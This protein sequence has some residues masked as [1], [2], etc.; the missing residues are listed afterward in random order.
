MSEVYIG[1]DLGSSGVKAVAMDESANCVASQSVPL[2]THRSSGGKAEHRTAEWQS[3]AG[4]CLR[5]LTQH[6]LELGHTPAGVACTGQ[7]NG[8][9]LLDSH[10]DPAAP[11][12]MWCDARCADQC[13]EI[14]ARI[15]AKTL[16]DIT[17]HHAVTGYTAP[18]LMWLAEHEPDVLLR[19]AH[20]VFPKDYL[21]FLLT[22]RV[23]TDFSDASNSLLLDVRSGR[24]EETISTTLGLGSVPLPPLA[25][26]TDVVGFIS[27]EGAAWSGLPEGLP[28]AGG[29]GD[30]IAAALGAGLKDTTA[31]QIVVGSAGNVNCV[32]G[33]PLVDAKGR[34]HTGFFVDR[35]HWICSGVLQAAGASLQ[36]WADIVGMRVDEMV[37]E[38]EPGGPSGVFFGPY[39]AGERT[40][41]LDARVRAGFMSLEGATLRADMTRAV[42]EGVAFAF[43]DAAE[44]FGEIEVHPKEVSITGGAARNEMFCRIMAE[45]LNTPLKRIDADVTARGAAILAACA[46]G[47]FSNW[48]ESTDAW[49]VPGEVFEPEEN[50]M[51]D[52]AYQ[53]FRRLYPRLAKWEA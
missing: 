22:G 15:P 35:S 53:R 8:P 30:S 9:V 33:E 12:Q 32:I 38:I 31:L 50:G 41:H 20:L 47:R 25:H 26:S 48:Q 43:R 39:L 16:L 13:E 46:A 2:T 45:V 49:P 24:W 40:P 23:G 11:V 19:C 18:K 29:A 27:R 36:W 42:L 28:V 34:V 7:M 51:Y 6:L 17:G 21:V 44:V 5:D 4:A 37:G 14:D 52:E 1:V 10:L 3:E